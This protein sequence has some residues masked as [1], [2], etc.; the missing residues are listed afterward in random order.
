ML[1]KSEIVSSNPTLAI[2]FQRNKMVLPHLL[3]KI[4][5]CGEPPW[6]KGNVLDLRSTGLKFR[7]L[8]LIGNVI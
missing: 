3:V 4:K 2:K 8:C 5:Y 6:L 7:I 1:E